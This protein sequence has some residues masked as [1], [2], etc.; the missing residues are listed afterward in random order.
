M[1]LGVRVS[2]ARGVPDVHARR[3]GT[4]VCNDC[5]PAAAVAAP[6]GYGAFQNDTQDISQMH[7]P[8]ATHP[9]APCAGANADPNFVSAYEAKSLSPAT[10]ARFRN[11]HDKLMA[12]ARRHYLSARSLDVLDIGCGA[13]TQCR[14]WAQRGHRVTGIDV[15]APLIATAGRRAREARLGIRFDVGSA[16]DLPYAD[17]TQDVVLLPQLLEHVPDWQR[18]LREA[19]RVLRP[20][21]LL[22]LSTSNVLCPVQSEFNLPLYS[23]YPRPLKRRYERLA[24]TTHPQL[25]NH[26]SFPAVHWFTYAQLARFLSSLGMRC[27]DRFDVLERDQLRGWRH[28]VARLLAAAPV[29][30]VPAQ[31]FV[32]TTVVFAVKP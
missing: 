6:I 15:S 13:G 22:Y 29:L 32:G 1:W 27:H 20:R 4:G 12:L 31:L 5:T 23:W 14:I 18:C 25:A 7:A 9:A 10:L 26:T 19:V 24:V 21:G 28:A 2:T 16:T 8:S 3:R 11:V 17:A 30:K